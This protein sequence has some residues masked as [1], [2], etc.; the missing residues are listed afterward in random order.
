MNEKEF[1]DDM[2][3]LDQLSITEQIER[4]NQ[5]VTTLYEPIMVIGELLERLKPAAQ[6]GLL[7]PT[8]Q[9]SLYEALVSSITISDIEWGSFTDENCQEIFDCLPDISEIDFLN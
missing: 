6:A 8:E 1:F 5:E 3:E 4:L 9:K 7:T 2:F